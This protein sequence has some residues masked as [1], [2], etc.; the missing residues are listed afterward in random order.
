MVVRTRFRSIFVPLVLFLLSGASG[1][2]FVWHGL[3]G[4]R[5]LNAKVA[6]RAKINDL[7]T[8]HARLVAI[9]EHME[10]RVAMMQ[11]DQVERDL[12]E[13]EARLVL[14]RVGK[15]DLVILTRPE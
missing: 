12:L 2:Y 7:S 9:R 3:N 6:Y 10:R 1:S 4:E 11:T 13:E 14:G 5:G 15:T 8:E